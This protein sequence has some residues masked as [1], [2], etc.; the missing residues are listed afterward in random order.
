MKSQLRQLA[1]RS[2]LL[3]IALLMSAVV[4]LAVVSMVSSAF[5]AQ[6]SDGLAAAINQSGSL[7]MQSY[8]IGVAL[9]DESVAA[10]ERSARAAAL[11]GEFEARL[12]S[13]RL[14]DAIPKRADSDAASAYERVRELW[15]DRMKDPLL[16]EIQL[17]AEDA[18]RLRQTV[19]R[20]A[21]LAGVDAFVGWSVRSAS[22]S[23]APT[24]RAGATSRCGSGPRGRTSSAAWARP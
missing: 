20:A 16:Q 21:Y 1:E 3:E 2:I 19:P 4:L 8:R 13:P 5:I 23:R 14:V 12:A 22:C 7:R 15:E 18:S 24:G 17:L 10:R 9:A 11:A 6:T